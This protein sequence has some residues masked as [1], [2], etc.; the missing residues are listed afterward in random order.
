LFQRWQIND[1]L[2]HIT[3]YVVHRQIND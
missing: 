2:D 3:F 1:F